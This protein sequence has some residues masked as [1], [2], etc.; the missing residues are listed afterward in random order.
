MGCDKSL[1]P[2]P[3]GTLLEW[4]RDRL[5]PGFAH[6][7]LVAKDVRRY[8]DFGLPVV[9]DARP[10][11]GPAVGV[12]TALMAS[13]APRTLCLACDMPFVTAAL[14]DRLADL[15]PPLDAL[16][17]RADDG[18]Q[19]LCAVYSRRALPALD[20]MLDEGELRLDRVVERVPMRYA[21]V[22]TLDV[23]DPRALF[24]NVNRPADLEVARHLAGGLPLN[25]V[26]PVD[27]LH[28]D[29]RTVGRVPESRDTALVHLGAR[30][31]D[32]I[33]R[34]P[35]PTVSFVGKKRSGKTTVLE[36][37][38]A[39]LVQR[40]RRVAAIKHDTHGFSVDAPGTGS[41]RM[42]AAGA[43]VTV[44]S[45]SEDVAVMS[46]V[47][48]EPAL[49]DLVARIRDR[50]DMVL[51]EGFVR[52]PAPKVEVSRAARS[53]TLIMPPEELLG[54]AADQPFPEMA[55]PQLALDDF[56]GVADLLERHIADHRRSHVRRSH[57]GAE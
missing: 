9:A 10:D 17:P 14:L 3:G 2:F 19:P 33:A 41:H 5:A 30:V 44:I 49:L 46:H 32:F 35:V 40:G 50:V 57:G 56:A 31:A 36:G 18:I 28:R 13:P 25:G 42:R 55:V 23:G 22:G 6:T 34:A 47:D 7:F 12:Y 43:T 11:A 51:T 20:A 29:P 37:V 4:L 26:P 48:E 53:G 27:A 38:I 15:A 21:D 1:A 54:I 24:F 39:E 16:V 8:G 52:Q 45:S